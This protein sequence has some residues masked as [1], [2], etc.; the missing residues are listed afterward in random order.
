ML[1]ILCCSAWTWR[2]AKLNAL[3]WTENFKASKRNTQQ[4]PP[5]IEEKVDCYSQLVLQP[6]CMFPAESFHF[7]YSQNL[8]D[9]ESLASK[10]LRL[11][12]MAAGFKH[13]ISP[14]LVDTTRRPYTLEEVWLGPSSQARVSAHCSLKPCAEALACE[15][16]WGQLAVLMQC[17]TQHLWHCFVNKKQETQQQF[18]LLLFL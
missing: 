1:I 9:R 8:V 3:H 17:C 6:G 7:C 4:H 13:Q 18:M 5:W 10:L 15:D 11:T 2:F 12:E 14:L 16:V